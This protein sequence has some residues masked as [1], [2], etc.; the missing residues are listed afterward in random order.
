M[1]LEEC[2]QRRLLPFIEK[3]GINKVLF[4]PDMATAHYANKVTDVLKAKNIDFVTKVQ[5]APNVPEA[6]GIERYWALCKSEYS[7]RVNRPKSLLGFKR[8]R[9]Q[10]SKKI[11]QKFGKAVMRK[12]FANLRKIGY[13]GVDA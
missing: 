12:A 1:Y 6:R 7:Q 8:V 13:E 9:T 4:W 10:I 11:A 2:I 5:N 3:I